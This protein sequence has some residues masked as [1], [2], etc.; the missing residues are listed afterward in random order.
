MKGDILIQV[1]IDEELLKEEM[2]KALQGLAK[3]IKINADKI[4]ADQKSRKQI[5]E[6][7]ARPN[8]T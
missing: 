7:Q 3:D 6:M 8:K 1:K 2:K 4:A 5:E